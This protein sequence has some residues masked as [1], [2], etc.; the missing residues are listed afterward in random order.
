MRRLK[1]DKYGIEKKPHMRQ[2]NV[3][4]FAQRLERRKT[5]ENVR[6][7][8]TKMLQNIH[9]KR[10]DKIEMADALPKQDQIS[11]AKYDIT[12]LVKFHLKDRNCDLWAR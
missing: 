6:K 8:P 12:T 4:K 7:K 5:V 1:K 11:H 2:H 9:I 3:L 10:T